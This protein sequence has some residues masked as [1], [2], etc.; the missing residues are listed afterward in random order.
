MKKI[1]SLLR[2][3]FLPENVDLALLLLRVW[4]GASLLLLH[5]W[6]KLSTFQ[7]MS[8]NFSDPLGIGSQAS[9]SLAVFG[10]VFC[11]F[12]LIIGFFARTAALGC[13]ITMGVAFFMVHEAA[14]K[15]GRSGE[16]AFIYLAGFLAILI[17]GPGRFAVAGSGRGKSAG[18]RP[19]PVRD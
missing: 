2:L 13:A 12:F 10:E 9:L 6:A 14:L 4:L 3:D 15:G 5:G 7:K 16:L 8:G 19:K 11:A 18:K 17:A 1:I